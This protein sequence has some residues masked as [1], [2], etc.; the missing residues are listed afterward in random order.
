MSDDTPDS[1]KAKTEIPLAP[2]AE[3]P[4]AWIMTDTVDDQ[5]KDNRREPNE[6]VSAEQ[7]RKLGIQYWKMDADAFE[8]PTMAVPW[9]PKDAMD[10]KLKALRDDRGYRYERGVALHGFRISA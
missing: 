2:D 5:C 3:W 4:E 10:P 6:P 9:D 7:L 8:Y 1:K